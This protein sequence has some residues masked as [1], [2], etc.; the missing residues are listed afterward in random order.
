[1]QWYGEDDVL[2][3][4][5]SSAVFRVEERDGQQKASLTIFAGIMVYD[6]QGKQKG[7]ILPMVRCGLAKL[8]TSAV[9]DMKL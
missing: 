5:V 6:I 4:K 1:M 8:K 9:G 7:R 3:R 2:D